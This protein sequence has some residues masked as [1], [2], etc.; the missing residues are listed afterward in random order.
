MEIPDRILKKKTTV[1]SDT[2]TVRDYKV[3]SNTDDEGVI[4]YPFYL[5]YSLIS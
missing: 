5:N 3:S 4:I 2:L 1:F